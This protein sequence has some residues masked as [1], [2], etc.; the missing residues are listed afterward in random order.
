VAWLQNVKKRA[1]R[2]GFP[3]MGYTGPNGSG[4]SAMMVWD[5]LP[6]LEAGRPVLGTVRLLDYQNPRECDDEACEADPLSGHYMRA[7]PEPHVV[8]AAFAVEPDPVK[9]VQLM[10]QLGQ[11]IGVHRAAH[12]LWIRLSD[13]QQVLD[14]RGVDLLLDEVTGAASS[15]ESAGLP[16]AVANK[17]VQMRRADVVIRW[18]AP[19]WARA[20]KILRETSQAVTYCRG[21]LPVSAGD[22]ARMWRRRR[23][24]VAKT[25]DAADFEDFTAGKRE[26]LSP[27]VSD[28]HWGPKS[29]AFLAYD[30]MDAV[31]TVGTV[32]ETGTCY[33]CGG[34][35][36]R[37]E[38]KGHGPGDPVA[39]KA[40]AKSAGRRR[41]GASPVEPEP[42][43]AM[44]P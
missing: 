14:A 11:I 1:E 8:E 4:K 40:A 5:T 2:R 19:A 31:S 9:R 44:V 13:W 37:H 30:T 41:R 20:D 43:P 39:V 16:A 34:N 3:I 28:L 12:P 18:S 15:R 17:L 26:E 35:R 29:P 21:R 10:S 25:Y 24:F 38:C 6:S 36:R 23:L 32:T 33:I 42:A 27:L 22:D 7:L